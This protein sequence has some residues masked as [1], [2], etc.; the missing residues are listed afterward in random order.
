[1]FTTVKGELVYI[2]S[3]FIWWIFWRNLGNFKV[4]SLSWW[5]GQELKKILMHCLVD[6]RCKLL[7]LQ[8]NKNLTVNINF[9]W[10]KIMGVAYLLRVQSAVRMARYLKSIKRTD[11]WWIRVQMVGLFWVEV[12]TADRSTGGAWGGAQE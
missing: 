5:K 2:H 11:F 12:V 8:V 9:H 3:W 10:I 1:M 4:I 7:L 6:V